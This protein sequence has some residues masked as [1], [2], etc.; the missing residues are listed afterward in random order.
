M[1]SVHFPLL[2]LLS[3]LP[4]QPTEGESI[5]V[6][7]IARGSVLSVDGCNFFVPCI[8]QARAGIKIQTWYCRIGKLVPLRRGVISYNFLALVPSTVLRLHPLNTWDCVSMRASIFTFSRPFVPQFEL[9]AGVNL[10]KCLLVA[11]WQG[12]SGLAE[13][14]KA[15]NVGRQG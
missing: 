9:Q 2:W 14:A 8:A 3:C 11:R 7:S 5:G 6:E 1:S 15:R 13:A 4:C 10:G 12:H